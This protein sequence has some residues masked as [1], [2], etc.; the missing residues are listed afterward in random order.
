MNLTK[1]EFEAT[2]KYLI[3]HLLDNSAYKIPQGWTL[4]HTEANEWIVSWRFISL[5]SPPALI[6]AI[7]SDNGQVFYI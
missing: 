5:S 7:I 2:A 4:T 1:S 3:W 6:N